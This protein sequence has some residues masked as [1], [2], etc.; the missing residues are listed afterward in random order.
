VQIP[1]EDL[2]FWSE[3]EEQA[4]MTRRGLAT[5]LLAADD[6]DAAPETP[7]IKV[8]RKE[9]HEVK[10]LEKLF[11]KLEAMGLSIDDYAL[12]QEESVTGEKLPTKYALWTTN[13]KSEEGKLMDVPNIAEIVP[14]VHEIGRQG[15][16]IKRY[17]GLGEMDADDLWE[18]TMNPERRTLLKVTWDAASEAEQLFSTLM[19]ENVEQRRKY[20]EDHALEVKNL[21]V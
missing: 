21:D 12:V 8:T 16:E 1:G 14:G 20:I 11:P 3:E 7:D 9:L 19:G 5:D 18:T 17:K 13:G 2:F 4:E 6:V 15:M 10:E